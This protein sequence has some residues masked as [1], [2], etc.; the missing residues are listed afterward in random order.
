M[1]SRDGQRRQN[2]SK[3]ACHR[4]EAVNPPQPGGGPSASSAPAEASLRE[5]Q[6]LMEQVVA[7][8]NMARALKRVEA[9]KGAP[10]TDGMSTGELRGYLHQEWTRIRRELLEGGYRPQPVKPVTIPKAGGGT[11]QLGIPTVLD[12]LIQ[13]AILQVLTPVFDPGFSCHSY[14]FRPGKRAH[15][16]VR[17]AQSY[18][19]EGYEWVVDLDIEKFFDRVNHDVLMARV[20]RKVSDKRLLKLIR[21]YLQAGVMVEGIRVSSQEG[22]PQGGP[23][24]P[25]LANILLDELDKELVARGHRFV[26]YADDLRIH[27]KSQR[28]G[29]RVLESTSLFLQKRLRLRV[30]EEK[31][32]VDRPWKRNFLGFSYFKHKGEV[33]IRLSSR[34][35]KRVKGKLRELTRRRYSQDIDLRIQRINRYLTGWLAYFALA[36]THSIFVKLEGWLR[37]RLRSCLWSLWKRV[38]TRYRELRSLGLSHWRAIRVANARKGPWFMAGWP[39]NSIMDRDF[40]EQK[41]LLNLSGRYCYLRNA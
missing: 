22:T 21:R 4:V 30:S 41:G 31:S 28:A 12:R 15:D 37:R 40:W 34:T 2:T 20:A 7:R 36:D 38:R 35:L 13:Q 9:N 33:R 24:S 8:E 11:R 1:S 27:V 32:V 18:I 26:R 25:L 3:E 19:Q 17:R 10:G 6:Q 23:L 14:G 5:E 29:E 39:L 16:A